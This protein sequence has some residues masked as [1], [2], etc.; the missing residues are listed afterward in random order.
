[1]VLDKGTSF[2]RASDLIV[3]FIPCLWVRMGV[4]CSEK[5]KSKCVNGL[6]FGTPL[7]HLK[8]IHVLSCDSCQLQNLKVRSHYTAFF[9]CTNL[10]THHSVG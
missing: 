10:T 2:V 8:P 1:M 7:D 3:Q 4:C 9:S 5:K 6:E